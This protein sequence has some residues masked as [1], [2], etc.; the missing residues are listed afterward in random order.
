M[1]ILIIAAGVFA[2]AVP[3]A[4]QP[5]PDQRDD[6][7]TR[8][9]PA[10]G[11]IAEMGDAL[12]RVADVMMDVDV[13]PIVDA[14]DPYHRRYGRR[15]HPR[16]IGDLASRDDPYARER[17]RASIDVATYGLE[18]AIRQIAIVT[19]VLR[20]SIEDATRRMD[21]AMR[22]RDY[23][24]DRDWDRDRDYE[25][26]RAPEADQD[27]AYDPDRDRDQDPDPDE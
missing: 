9:L 15:Y 13:G 18:A 24:R 11:E 19:P 6:E 25:R 21:D 27:R 10:P 4:A 3:A 22:S 8:D 17:I 23:R 20:R 12:G 14:V 2:F 16:T 1:R 7:I 26:D 5:G